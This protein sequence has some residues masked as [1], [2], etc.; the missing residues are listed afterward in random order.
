MG[1]RKSSVPST[2][3]GGVL[4]GLVLGAC[5]AEPQKGSAEDTH[6]EV[7]DG[8]GD[9]TGGDGGT[10]DGGGDDG[11]DDGIGE[12]TVVVS[13]TES[14]EVV[15]ADPDARA[16]GGP[17]V[18]VHD[19]ITGLTVPSPDGLP[20]GAGAS[21]ADLDGDGHLDLFHAQ[22]NGV[23]LYI[24]DGLGGLTDVSATHLPLPPAAW[25]P[26]A[27]MLADVDGDGDVDALVVNRGGTDALWLNDGTAHFSLAEASGLSPEMFA[28]AGATFGDIDGDGDLDLFVAGHYASAASPTERPPADASVV[29]TNEGG[30]F[31]LQPSALPEDVG[32]GYTFNGTLID[33]D[34][35]GRLDLYVV[36]DHGTE[37]GPNR[38]LRGVDDGGVAR[39]ESWPEA[40]L[41]ATMQGMGIAL[42]DTNG[43]AVPDL[44]VTNFGQLRLFESLS[45]GVWYESSRSRGIVQ[46]DVTQVVGWGA[47]LQDFD[48]DGNVDVWVVFGRLGTSREEF[49][50]PQEQPDALWMQDSEGQFVDNGPLWG[51]D[52]VS[53]ARGALAADFNEDGFLDMVTV[54][55][56]R[57]PSLY[58]SRCDDAAWLQVA[59]HWEGP[60]VHGVGA[61]V[62]IQTGEHLMRRW[63]T[64]GGT[65]IFGNP[66]PVAHVG[67]GNAEQV[68]VRVR[69]PDGETSVVPDVSTRQ[70]ILLSRAADPAR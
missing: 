63:I 57:P 62:E 67:L 42:G 2:M 18:A 49:E 48:N 24:G 45:E 1:P 60:N 30:T 32:A 65:T 7:S 52:D 12:E 61:L 44:L 64:A 13:V 3:P 28:S 35:D 21:A 43:D 23:S 26:H 69:W 6:A 53:H 9:G 59:L 46:D 56:N 40:G 29:Y 50:N 25:R 33:L 10:D 31:V 17:M 38:M 58:L 47:E 34:Q 55:L 66:P 41:D 8:G 4:W 54:P 15:C 36:N 27:V 20:A 11:G 16:L 39:F 68:E 51:I 19:R 22:I 5:V 14:G 70:R 37:G